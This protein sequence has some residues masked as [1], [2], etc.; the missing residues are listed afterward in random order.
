MTKTKLKYEMIV[1]GILSLLL[2]TKHWE[3]ILFVRTRQCERDDTILW[4]RFCWISKIW[5]ANKCIENILRIIK[6]SGSCFASFLIFD[7]L[8][9][10]PWTRVSLENKDHSFTIYKINVNRGLEIELDGT[11]TAGTNPLVKPVGHPPTSVAEI[12]YF[13]CSRNCPCVVVTFALFHSLW[14]L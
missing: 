14:F 9:Y 13:F 4:F 11:G 5:T 6:A 12:N 7:Y 10:K 2:R 8:L 3:W 1:T